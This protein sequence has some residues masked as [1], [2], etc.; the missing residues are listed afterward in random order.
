M[1]KPKPIYELLDYTFVIPAYQRGYRWDKEQVVALLDDLKQFILRNS[2][3]RQSFS[4]TLYYCLQ[5]MAVVPENVDCESKKKFIVVD[6]Q[7]RLTTLYLL[8]QYLRPNSYYSKVPIFSL[9]LEA[10]KEQQL[11][12]DE[13]KYRIDG[14]TTHEINIDNFYIR[15]AFETINEWFAKEEPRLLKSFSAILMDKP[16][17]GESE[18]SFP[19]VRVIW[20]EIVD[21]KARDA[22][23]RLNFGKI[24][25]TS[26]ELVKALLLQNNGCDSIDTFKTSTAYRRAL[27]WDLMERT[28]Q[29]PYLWS[30][31]AS[32]D[33]GGLSRLDLIL[34]FVADDLNRLI[35]TTNPGKEFIRKPQDLLDVDKD[36]RDY[37]NYN[38][39]E[40]VISNNIENVDDPI[41]AIWRRI[42][43]IFN[44]IT[45]WYE[46]R[47]WYH[48]IGLLRILPKKRR[49]NRDFVRDIYRMS[50]DSKGNPVSRP[51]F[52]EA[53][54]NKIAEEIPVI[55]A[56]K[57]LS[58]LSYDEDSDLMRAI[59]KVLNVKTAIDD[60][61][62][63]NR[64]S[65]H[66]FDKYNLISLD[67]IHPQTI[68]LSNMPYTVFS[69]WLER[70]HEDIV[71]LS[72]LDFEI[73][74][75]RKSSREGSEEELTAI[76]SEE[77]KEIGRTLKENVL[78]A[79]NTIRLIAK[80][81]KN[82]SD[83]NNFPALEKAVK[84]IDSLFGQLTGIEPEELHSLRNMALVDTPTNAALQNFMLDRKREILMSRHARGVKGDSDG[85]YAMPSTRKVYS[86]DYSRESPGDMRF[87]RKEDRDNYFV[88]ISE[89]YNY[90]KNI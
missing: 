60:S 14:D 58:S 31:L 12:L 68:T 73:A 6:G 53:L 7:Q 37:F 55:P 32:P 5:P 59:L 48:F 35:K 63:G 54:K 38:V 74:A 84:V 20:Y 10:R 33:N 66:L 46:D 76:T 25:L 1:I 21:K 22:F 47:E 36:A 87:W 16:L 9:K 89:A 18:D 90:F 62:D 72:D 23:R 3:R 26:T 42:R 17:D 28:L 64:F 83:S 82:Y 80:D 40:T 51:D 70:R 27:E 56:N 50:V 8:M 86:K 34:D 49:N 85:T 30:M 75:S 4:T 13:E 24:P 15:K 11:Y 19:N 57:T 88:A 67:H 61:T 81:A 69:E 65:F 52:S 41:D 29:D 77:I 39:V 45:N 43:S 44:L 79:E 71:S 2:N 78:T